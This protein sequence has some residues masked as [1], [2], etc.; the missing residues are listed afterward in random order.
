MNIIKSIILF[1]RRL[2]TCT[3]IT[4]KFSHVMA[5]ENTS[6]NTSGNYTLPKFEM[7][8]SEN[9]TRALGF[10]TECKKHISPFQFNLDQDILEGYIDILF[11]RQK[12]KH[13]DI[14]PILSVKSIQSRSNLKLKYNFQPF[15]GVVIMPSYKFDFNNE[16]KF[17]P[18]IN[19]GLNIQMGQF[20]L[21]M[22][23]NDLEE[24]LLVD[25]RKISHFPYWEQCTN[26]IQ[27]N[28][29]YENTPSNLEKEKSEEN[30]TYK[31]NANIILI[32]DIKSFTDVFENQTIASNI[33]FGF[34]YGG[35]NLKFGARYSYKNIFSNNFFGKPYI[36]LTDEF[37]NLEARFSGYKNIIQAG[38]SSILDFPDNDSSIQFGGYY[39][40]GQHDSNARS[41][42]MLDLTGTLDSSMFKPKNDLKMFNLGFIATK[43]GFSLGTSYTN[44]FNTYS[45]FGTNNIISD[46]LHVALGYTQGIIGGSIDAVVARVGPHKFNGISFSTSCNLGWFVPHISY[47]I[48]DT[49]YV[50]SD[51][52]IDKN[53]KELSDKT[54]IS[55]DIFQ[56]G[57]VK[58]SSDISRRY[59]HL[60]V[61]GVKLVF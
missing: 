32:P 40:Y 9:A 26:Y 11:F 60:L 18:L 21:F 29:R 38:L 56:D 51:Y 3:V 44:F 53:K 1:A 6:V 36:I 37:N 13:D 61:L 4:L 19:L 54:F 42:N 24:R 45:A 49:S 23:Q 35:D 34:L 5:I 25:P 41:N 30:Y 12:L 33:S 22:G 50:N 2:I 55:I 15:D 59:L 8:K 57:V 14:S 31:N 47:S 10:S 16:A 46:K 7:V 39:K 58:G 17:D 20:N 52:R 27:S 48:A 43:S 28:L